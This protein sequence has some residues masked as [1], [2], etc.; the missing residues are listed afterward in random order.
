VSCSI[1][2]IEPNFP[3]NL[4]IGQVQEGVGENGQPTYV[5]GCWTV[6]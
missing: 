5:E 6:H 1:S 2:S 3:A 4:C